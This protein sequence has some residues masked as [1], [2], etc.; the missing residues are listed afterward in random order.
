MALIRRGDLN[1][2]LT[3]EELDGNFDYLEE[4]SSGGSSVMSVT[5]SSVDNTDPLNPVILDSRGYK[6][7]TALVSQD[8]TNNPTLD[9]VQENTFPDGT[10][11]SLTR[12]ATGDYNC[13]INVGAVNSNRVN[14]I[15]GESLNIVFGGKNFITSTSVSPSVITF[16]IRTI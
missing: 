10:I 16:K 11:L 9:Y 4:L 7:Y 2:P 14:I 15:I 12:F 8:S 1:R 5:G 13:S 6:V 3:T